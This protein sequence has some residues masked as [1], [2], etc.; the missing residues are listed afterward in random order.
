MLVVVGVLGVGRKAIHNRHTISD[1][2]QGVR[3][4]A[5][6]IRRDLLVKDRQIVRAN[7]FRL[8]L[9]A[10]VVSREMHERPEDSIVNDC[11]YHFLTSKCLRRGRSR[12]SSVGSTR[13]VFHYGERRIS[14]I[15]RN[16]CA[17]FPSGSSCLTRNSK[18][19]RRVPSPRLAVL[20]VPEHASKSIEKGLN[21]GF[22]AKVENRQTPNEQETSR[23]KRAVSSEKIAALLAFG[24][25]CS[26]TSHGHVQ[27]VLSNCDGSSPGQAPFAA[28]N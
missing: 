27:I 6:L 18:N 28:Q 15:V 14:L 26:Q 8:C 19:E 17:L 13:S 21:T 3:S 20:L 11:S 2:L 24:L 23:A 9:R 12:G 5:P 16:H 7:L 10:T 25:S 22:N 4:A 1:A